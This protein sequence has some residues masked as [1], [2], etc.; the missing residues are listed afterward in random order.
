M[1]TSRDASRDVL[2]MAGLLGG[3]LL[4]AMIAGLSFLY[5]WQ[6]NSIQALT[7][8]LEE[9]R[10]ALEAEQE[11]NRILGVRID[12]AF[13]LERVARIARDQLRMSEPKQDDIHYVPIPSE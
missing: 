12:E 10:E 8:D 6:G 2:P 1:G 5:L 13:S 7:A 4:A 3:I 11:I 9:A